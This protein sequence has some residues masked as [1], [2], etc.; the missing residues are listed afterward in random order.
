MLNVTMPA[1]PRWVQVILAAISGEQTVKVA[2]A[3]P[4]ETAAS[5]RHSR[6]CALPV[7]D[8]V[9]RLRDAI[10]AADFRVLHEIDPQPLLR[11]GSY[12]IG[13]ARQILFFHPR[14]TARLLAAGPA[15]LIEA[16]LKCAV[17]EMPG[18]AVMARWTDPAA[19]FARYGNTVLA[20]LGREPAAA[21]RE[22]AAAARLGSH[23]A[24]AT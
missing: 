17:L 5:F 19:A 14:V 16:P 7:P 23:V 21:R 10:A 12:A 4:D 15:I 8:A 13:A 9:V 3:D 18:S 22:I 20:D 1:S 2:C 24:G 6:M 11:R